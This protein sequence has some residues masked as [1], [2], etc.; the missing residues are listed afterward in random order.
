LQRA[1]TIYG[2]QG[3]SQPILGGLGSLRNVSGA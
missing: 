1:N 2:A 3:G